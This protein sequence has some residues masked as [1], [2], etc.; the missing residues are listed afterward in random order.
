MEPVELS[1]IDIVAQDAQQ[2]SVHG[3]PNVIVDTVEE[4][5]TCLALN[6]FTVKNSNRLR[7]DAS[8]PGK[9]LASQAS[10]PDIE[11]AKRDATPLRSSP[12]SGFI[13]IWRY[14]A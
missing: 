4:A 12:G 8:K 2:R 9:V 5:T 6:G 14:K 13:L 1:P 7:Q 10:K 11:S 3:A